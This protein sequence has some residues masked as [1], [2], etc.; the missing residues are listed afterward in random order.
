LRRNLVH[1]SGDAAHHLRS[2]LRRKESA[3]TLGQAQVDQV[4]PCVHATGI[5]F[6]G[7][8]EVLDGILY[9][10]PLE[11]LPFVTAVGKQLVGFALLRRGLRYWNSRSSRC[12]QGQAKTGEAAGEPLDE[13]AHHLDDEG[14]VDEQLFGPE[15]AA[16]I[17]ADHLRAQAVTRGHGAQLAAEHQI[18]L[19]LFSHL[20]WRNAAAS[21]GKDGIAGQDDGNGDLTGTEPGRGVFGDGRTEI[22][23]NAEC[24]QKGKDGEPGE[25]GEGLRAEGLDLGGEAIAAPGHGLN[26]IFG[27]KMFGEGIETLR[28]AI[29][30]RG[31]AAKEGVPKL[32]KRDDLT[33]MSEEQPKGLKLPGLD[34]DRRFSA[35]ERAIGLQ[36]EFAKTITCLL[37]T[38]QCRVR[39]IHSNQRI[40]AR[41]A[42]PGSA[43]GQFRLRE[44]GRGLSGS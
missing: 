17:H 34:S 21:E 23:G 9:A 24:G 14:T 41:F 35:Q 28:D 16:V 31:L 43:E 32:I 44:Q 13:I 39:P 8:L 7:A 4:D 1:G 20:A 26:T 6:E 18:G 27:L 30:I 38:G 36:A 37:G 5:E 2:G 12:R 11:S 42:R 22:L 40:S 3:G 19:H 33:R 15:L 29:R 25:G 10:M